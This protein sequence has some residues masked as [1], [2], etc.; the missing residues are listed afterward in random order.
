MSQ[1]LAALPV[2]TFLAAAEYL[3]FTE[4]VAIGRIPPSLEPFLICPAIKSVP[5]VP[6]GRAVVVKDDR[7]QQ[8]GVLNVKKSHWM[9]VLA[10][11]AAGG[12]AWMSM[13]GS[14][15]VAQQGPPPAGPAAQIALLDVSLCFKE[16]PTFKNELSQIND[17]MGRADADIKKEN[18]DLVRFGDSLRDYAVGS[19][20]YK[21]TEEEIVRRRTALQMRV[22]TMKQE[23]QLRL[24]QVHNRVYQEI[25]QEVDYY[26]RSNGIAMVLNYDSSKVD[27]N[28]PE[29]VA[30]M[31]Y[32]PVVF[33]DPRLDITPRIIDTLRRRAGPVANSNGGPG[34]VPAP[35]QGVG[36][37]R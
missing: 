7:L 37:P 12:V 3:A 17:D 20:E 36:F 28:K 25:F 16:H 21:R 26:C 33:R 10:T 19:P 29:E 32:R 6:Q 8:Q 18:A 15:A 27:V 4:R 34:P 35:T 9:A 30:R 23:F 13:A 24:S 11:C 31:V 14:S 5:R 22:Q 1:P 2:A